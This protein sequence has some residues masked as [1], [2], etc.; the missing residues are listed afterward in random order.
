M[1]L[2]IDRDLN[3]V[4]I[5]LQVVDS[6]SFTAAAKSL[7]NPTGHDIDTLVDKILAAKMSQHQLDNSDIS[8]KELE[9]CLDTFKSL[10][11]SIYHVRIEYPEEGIKE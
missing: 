5:F 3:D 8:F 4:L 10:L 9:I 7:K 6:G 2:S 11:R 1:A